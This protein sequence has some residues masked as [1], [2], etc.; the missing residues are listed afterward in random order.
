L[1]LGVLESLLPTTNGKE[2]NSFIKCKVIEEKLRCFSDT[3]KLEVGFQLKF[4][5]LCSAGATS[6]TSLPYFWM[7]TDCYRIPLQRTNAFLLKAKVSFSI[8]FYCVK[9]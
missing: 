3:Q 9:L 1:F 8:S 6:V 2:L 4:D 7:S 5:K